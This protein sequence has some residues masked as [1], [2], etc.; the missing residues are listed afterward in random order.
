M[1]RINTNVSSINAQKTLARSNASLQESLTRLSTGLRINSGKDDPA[2]LIAS[3]VL[4]SDIVSVER[5]ITNSER[6]NQM[7]ATADSALG[8]VSS[9]LNDIRGLV[10]EAANT[11]AMSSEQI[12]ANQLQIDSSLEA[13]DRIA[14]TTK[15]QGQTLL[16]GSLDFLTTGVT[17]GELQDVRIDQANF[18]S[19]SQIDV[20]VEVVAQATKAS[21]NY[22]HG[23]I[24]EDVVLEVGGKNGFEAFSFAAGS[25]IEDMAKAINL[26]SDALGVTAD[27]QTEAT[28]GSLTVSSFGAD[29]DIVLTANNA[30]FDAGNIQVKYTAAP[31][32]NNKLT[33]DYVRGTGGSPGTLNI[34]LKTTE[35]QQAVYEFGFDDTVADNAFTITAQKAGADYNGYTFVFNTHATTASCTVDTASKQV[36]ITAVVGAISATE[37]KAAAE[38]SDH[39]KALFAF[40]DTADGGDG[41]GDVAPATIAA[42]V[43]QAKEDNLGVDGGAIES[44]ANDIVDLLNNGVETTDG[45]GLA[46][47]QADLTASLAATNDGHEVVT[48]FQEAAYYGTS[49]ADNR[50]QFLG[51]EGSRNIRFVAE[52]GNSLGV[53]LSTEARIE[54]FSSL[55]VNLGEDSGGTATSAIKITAKNK[56]ADYDDVTVVF[57]ADTGA[58]TAGEGFAVWDAKMKTLTIYADHEEDTVQDIIDYIQADPVVGQYFR[59]EAWGATATDNEVG[60]LTDG[61]TVGQTSGGVV[62]EGTIIVNLETDSNG[63]IKTTAQDLID[64]FDA[65]PS[66]ILADLGISVSNA[67]GSDGSGLLAATVADLTFATNG[68]TV[69]DAYATA[70]LNTSGGENAMFDITAK[71]AGSAYEGVTIQFEGTATDATKPTFAWDAITKTLTIGIVDGETTADDIIDNVDDDTYENYNEEVDE[72]FSFALTQDIYESGTNS[73]GSGLL[74]ITDGATLANG[75]STT[76]TATGVALLGNSDEANTGLT[77]NATDYGSDSF[78]SIKSLNGGSFNTTDTAGNS[79][80]RVT[81]TDV[82]ALINGVRALGKGLAASINTSALDVSFSVSATMTDGSSS[83]FAIVGGGAVFQLGPDVVS[84]QQARLG[85]SSVN[86]AKLG[87]TAGRLYQSRSG[88]TASLENDTIAAAAIV[89]E[90]ITGVVTLRGRLGAFQSTTLDSNI[91]SLEDTLENLTE[92]ESNIRDADFAAE[93]AALTRNQILVQSGISVLAMANQNPQAV[94]SLLR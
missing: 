35:W 86:T 60:A 21:L 76:G 32:G 4:R 33:A 6:A 9:L 5:A 18:G 43:S 53:D 56:G 51:A 57:G 38:T 79:V 87:G 84:N 40:D 55:I 47:L 69:E 45:T 89:E 93:S 73:D 83:S 8:Q 91:A 34:N 70:T 92:A 50:L 81:G 16:D 64:Y 7:I 58:G 10:S 42:A 14:Q 54:S 68:Q 36:T 59:A 17:A 71:I 49:E 77:F 28:A 80:E 44:T 74:Y 85:I 72:L 88:N 82:N 75:T 24:A 23:A 19:L 41:S 3:E 25:T 78:V 62:S 29:N 66:G 15:F 31:E 27:V 90:A 2:G 48:T 1:T 39:F 52:A 65:D 30:G 63:L 11:G 94:L 22:E 20:N 37:Y 26:V 12:A 61:A 67:E 46:E 13:I